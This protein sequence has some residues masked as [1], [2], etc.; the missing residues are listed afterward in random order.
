ETKSNRKRAW[1]WIIGL[2][3]LGSLFGSN[4]G[5]LFVFGIWIAGMVTAVSWMN[6]IRRGAARFIN[7]LLNDIAGGEPG[8][9][10]EW[11]ELWERFGK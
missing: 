6:R 3:I 5:A 4:I 1:R 7:R 9:S 2:L 8:D 11:L 10:P